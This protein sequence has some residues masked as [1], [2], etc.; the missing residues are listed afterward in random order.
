M[1]M[2]R[3][4]HPIGYSL[5]IPL[6]GGWVQHSGN[7]KIDAIVYTPSPTGWVLF[8]HTFPGTYASLHKDAIVY[9]LIQ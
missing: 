2:E 8:D 1:E 3:P 7:I 5:L 9:N 6:P 4:P